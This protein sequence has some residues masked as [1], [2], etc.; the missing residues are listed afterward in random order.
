MISLKHSDVIK[1]FDGEGDFSEWVRKF[2]LVCKIQKLENLHDVIPLF[3]ARDAFN[4]YE[5][6]S[7]SVKND[8]SKIKQALIAS[9]SLDCFSAYEEFSRRTL[10]PQESIDTYLSDLKRLGGLMDERITENILL[11][12]FVNGLP[13]EMKNLLKSMPSI[14]D[15]SLSELVEKARMID[16]TTQRM[17]SIQCVA[18]KE[19]DKIICFRCKEPGHKKGDR[20]CRY[21]K[22]KLCFICSS[23]LHFA[24]DCPEKELSK[25]L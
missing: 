3:L 1:Q 21:Y 22:E 2:E 8:Y 4:V 18:I 5:S 24:R 20:S 12:A 7:E 9:Y 13:N 11:L 19:S 10:R 16:R 6:L 25:N 23:N 14:M 15:I 17:Q